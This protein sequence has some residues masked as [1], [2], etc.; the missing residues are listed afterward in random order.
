MKKVTEEKVISEQQ[1]VVVV[2][3]D[4]DGRVLMHDRRRMSKMGEE[5]ALVGGIIE[6]GEAPETAALREMQEEVGYQ[7]HD[8]QFFKTYH[9]VYPDGVSRTAHV[10]LAP[11]PG[12]EALATISSEIHRD[13]LHLFSLSEARQL[14]TLPIAYQMFDDVADAQKN[15]ELPFQK[16]S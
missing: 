15:G 10:F 7:P 3:L 2:F 16:K 13:E 6:E 1:A 12:F 8:L 14:R 11:F 5:W 9:A 4:E